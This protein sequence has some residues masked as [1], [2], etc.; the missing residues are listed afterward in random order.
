MKDIKTL[1]RIAGIYAD[2]YIKNPN[3]KYDFMNG[4]KQSAKEN[5]IIFSLAA[6]YAKTINKDISVKTALEYQ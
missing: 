6:V 5:Y 2:K 1:K 3:M 4:Y